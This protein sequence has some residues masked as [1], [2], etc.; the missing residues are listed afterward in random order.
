MRM[1]A[2]EIWK[3]FHLGDELEIAGTQIYN[4]L[5]RFHEMRALDHTDEIFDFIYNISIGL[6]RLL[7]IC[8]ILL[9]HNENVDQDAL[10][11]SLKTHNHLDLLKRVRRHIKLNIGPPHNDFLAFLGIFYKSFRYDRFTLSSVY[12]PHREKKALHE[13]LTKYLNVDLNPPLNMMATANDDRYRKFI[14]KTVITI[15]S[16]LY[17]VVKIKATELNLYTYEI[18]SGSKAQ[19]VFFHEGNIQSEEI[20]WKELLI[21]FM[22]TK[23]T[24]GPLD[25]LRSI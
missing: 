5:R 2:Q 21:F 10:E 24:S 6:E 25:F 18:R 4:G 19:T 7:K 15:S 3:N 8:V 11:E 23:S 17:G 1:T 20:L 14:R 9:E 13:F 16:A 22:N 12:D